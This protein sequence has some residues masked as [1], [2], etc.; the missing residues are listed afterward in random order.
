M[1]SSITDKLSTLTPPAQTESVLANQI[2]NNNSSNTVN[3][4]SQL[5]QPAVTEAKPTEEMAGNSM[6]LSEYYLQAIHDSLII[7]G[8]KIRTI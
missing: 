7:H 6:G 1:T 5:A 8:I 3:Q 2:V 4:S